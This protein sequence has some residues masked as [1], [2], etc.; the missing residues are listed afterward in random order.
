M[1]L[2]DAVTDA[3]LFGDMKILWDEGGVKL[4]R[5]STDEICLYEMKL[6]PEGRSR[7]TIQ[8]RMDENS[9]HLYQQIEEDGCII[10]RYVYGAGQEVAEE[11]IR[12][13]AA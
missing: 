2:P 12:K 6:T 4:T 8:R 9:E 7:P 11:E 3:G 5:F 13:Y 1:Q 10:A